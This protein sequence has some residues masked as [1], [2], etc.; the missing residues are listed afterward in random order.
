MS[1]EI[2]KAGAN[3][4]RAYNGRPAQST[5]DEVM[6]AIAPIFVAFPQIRMTD[7]LMRYHCLMLR[8]IS[9]DV[10]SRAVLDALAEAEFPPTVGTIRK[11]LP[12]KRPPE[13]N[14]NVDWDDLPPVPPGG[15][16]MFRLSH[17]EDRRQRME[18][19]HNTAKWESKYAR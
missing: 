3:I 8:D 5:D 18:R 19:L 6:R 7:E 15:F 17:E 13:A 16:K 12:E 1:N 11:Q 4:Q 14:S 10:L 9:P 2:E